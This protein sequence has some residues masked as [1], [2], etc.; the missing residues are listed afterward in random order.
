MSIINNILS[1]FYSGRLKQIDHFMRCS[2][3]VQAEQFRYLL[4]YAKNTAWGKE[5]DY[6]SIKSVDDFKERVPIRDYEGFMPYIIRLRQGEKNLLW[7]GVIKLFA[8]SSGTTNSKSKFIPISKESL[9]T[10]HFRGGHDV[11]AMYGS[12]YPK[13]KLFSGRTLT[14]GGSQQINNFSNK[15]K[16]YY[17]D[18]SALLIKNIP[19]WTNHFRTPNR[20]IALL[21]EW[22][23]KINL[24]TET[25]IKQNVTGLTGV[26]S[27]FLDRKSVV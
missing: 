4:N 25:T 8:K 18:L 23:Q 19:F 9:E 12:M 21:S 3:D 24:I 7:P 20:K 14:L 26:P 16:S 11:L 15:S 5:Y 27:W 1:A 2:G 22:E 13:N 17:G 6:A 10:C